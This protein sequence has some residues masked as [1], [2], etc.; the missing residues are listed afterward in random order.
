MFPEQFP[1]DPGGKK[2]KLRAAVEAS[3]KE[4]LAQRRAGTLRGNKLRHPAYAEAKQRPA[5]A[6]DT[7]LLQ[8]SQSASSSVPVCVSVIVYEC[9]R[10]CKC[11]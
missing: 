6:A 5:F 9:V 2:E 1:N 7:E 10:E 3:L 11:V 8:V 4:A